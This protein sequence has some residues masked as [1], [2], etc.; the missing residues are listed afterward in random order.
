MAQYRGDPMA[1][2]PKEQAALQA[3]QA[4]WQLAQQQ[5]AFLQQQAMQGVSNG[6]HW[7]TASSLCGSALNAA[8]QAYAG[9][10]STVAFP[11]VQ[12]FTSGGPISNA[13]FSEP[14]PPEPIEDAGITTGEI[15][16][17]R[18]WAISDEGYL[19]SMAATAIWGIDGLMEGDPETYGQ[20]V[21]AFKTQQQA[22]QE[23]GS[24]PGCH[25]FGRVALWGVVIEHQT[26]YRAQYA[27]IIAIDMVVGEKRPTFNM[28]FFL[29]KWYWRKKRFLLLQH[30]RQTYNIP[31]DGIPMSP[32]EIKE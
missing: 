28:P 30:L 16:G 22:L 19:H 17:H 15:I 21:H 27:K 11:V 1:L 25:A 10:L 23:Y 9:A 5:A 13:G 31:D 24:L 6:L 7:Q 18:A 20:G 4:Q 29:R 8:N 32:V 12:A 3:A 26:G 2:T 14:V